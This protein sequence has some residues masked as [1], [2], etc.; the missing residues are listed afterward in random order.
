MAQRYGGKYS[1]DGKSAQPPAKPAQSFRNAQVD[2]VGMSTILRDEGGL[3]CP[4]FNDFVEATTD[5]VDGWVEGVPG[6]VLMNGYAASKLWVK[7]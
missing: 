6:Q 2:P 1:P 5:K 3:I 7:A 4:M